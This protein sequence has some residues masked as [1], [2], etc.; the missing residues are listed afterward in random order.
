MGNSGSENRRSRL[1]FALLLSSIAFG[2]LLR[3]WRL[4][5]Q[6]VGGDEVHGLFAATSLPLVNVATTYFRSDTGL[7]LAAFY[8]AVLDSGLPLTEL[9]LRGPSVAAGLA[10]L[11]IL[12][13]FNYRRFGI[14]VA[15]IATALLAISPLHVLLS[16]M[17]RPYSLATLFALV[18]LL[19]FDRWWRTG[20][21]G[22]LVVYAVAAALVVYCNLVFTPFILSPFLFALSTRRLT[23]LIDEN[24]KPFA[25]LLPLSLAGLLLSTCLAVVLWPARQ[26]LIEVV[27]AKSSSSAIAS[28]TIESFFLNE[29]GTH[30]LLLALGFWLLAPRWVLLAPEERQTRSPLA[31]DSDPGPTLW[32]VGSCSV[33]SRL[34]TRFRSLS[35]SDSAP[36]SHSL[37]GWT[38]G[39]T[40]TDL[41]I[42]GSAGCNGSRPRSAGCYR[43]VR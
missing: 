37:C 35:D 22:A 31:D 4:A 39:S 18:A 36:G 25:A 30:S 13:V 40:A 33:W 28:Y 12:G 38:E 16:R 9:T 26:S 15:A 24:S 32:R 17:A 43:S 2:V 6:L 8:R 14:T 19:A 27:A 1:W 7:P 23:P 20:H 29:A 42:L 10:T 21:R 5:E 11:I 3:I 41:A 34:P